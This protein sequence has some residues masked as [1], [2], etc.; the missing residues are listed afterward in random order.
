MPQV[1]PPAPKPTRGLT[2]QQKIVAQ[3]CQS[4]DKKWWLPQ[5]FMRGGEFFVGYEASARL[6]ELQSD[7]PDMF[8][9]QRN[10]K[11]IERRIKFETIGEWLSGS[12]TLKAVVGK[13][14]EAL[15]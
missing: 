8:E 12:G 10:G 5:D 1:T 7:Y 4:P 9:S 13:Y 3:M 15:K 2:Q 6:S 11:Y 14:Y